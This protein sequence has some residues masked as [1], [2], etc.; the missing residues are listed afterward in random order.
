MIKNFKITNGELSTFLV[1]WITQSLSALGSAMTN[2]VLVIWSYQQQGSAL[3]TSLLAI[4]SYAPYVLLSIFAGALSDRWNKKITMLV[5][6]SFAALCT[7]TV[8]FLLTTDTLAEGWRRAGTW[9]GEHRYRASNFAGEHFGH[10]SSTAQ[11]QSSSHMQ[12]L[13]FFHEYRELYPCLWEEHTSLVCGRHHG[14]A[15]HPHYEC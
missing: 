9:H 8:L 6:D 14:M 7:V 13:A 3:T 15:I 11:K 10:Y 12:F 1:L 4:C 2:F 5:S